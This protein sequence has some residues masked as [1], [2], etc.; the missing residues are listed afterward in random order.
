[1]AVPGGVGPKRSLGDAQVGIEAAD[2]KQLRAHEDERGDVVWRVGLV[3][4]ADSP[5]PAGL[6][7]VSNSWNARL[8]SRAVAWPSTLNTVRLNVTNA[9]L[10]SVNPK[11]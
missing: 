1:M 9:H 10:E 2:R 5:T 7:R 11:I 6:T 8:T 4:S 3:S